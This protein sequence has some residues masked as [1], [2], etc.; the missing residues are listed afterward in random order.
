MGLPSRSR[1]RWMA[2]AGLVAGWLLMLYLT[3]SAVV[4][5]GVLVLVVALGVCC[6]LSLRSLGIGPGH[7]WVRQFA[8]RPWSDGQRD[9]QYAPPHGHDRQD[10][11]PRG[12]DGWART[13]AI[14]AP[15]AAGTPTIAEPRGP[16]VPPLRLVTGGQVVRTTT[17]GARAG[18]GAVELVLPQVLTISREH[19]RFTFA[20]GQWWVTNLGRNGLAVNGLQVTGDHPVR[21]GD[22]IR[23]G[24]RPDAPVSRVEIG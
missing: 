4:G 8:S 23:W 6:W 16:V 24:G 15:V 9:G 12:H 5:T 13:E 20:D 19:A 11:P 21:D 14:A 7:P 17:P 3:G 1:A 2:A 22:V 18:R 10:A